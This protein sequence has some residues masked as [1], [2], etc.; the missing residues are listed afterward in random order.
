MSRPGFTRH[1]PYR[2]CIE[3]K[4]RRQ[5]RRGGKRGGRSN[6]WGGTHLLHL[7]LHPHRRCGLLVVLPR[8]R[9]KFAVFVAFVIVIVVII[10]LSMSLTGITM[11]TRKRAKKAYDLAAF[12]GNEGE[13]VN[14]GLE[15]H[16]R[17]LAFTDL[18]FEKK[19]GEDA[20]GRVFLRGVR[21]QRDQRTER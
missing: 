8:L 11:V 13:D 14:D 21:H 6:R 3:L 12:E 4:W 20:F 18:T 7:L 5:L 10:V 16:F 1:V 15:R 9:C 2:H 19:I 17:E